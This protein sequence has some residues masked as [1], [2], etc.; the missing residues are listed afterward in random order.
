M[1]RDETRGSIIKQR[2]VAPG[3]TH[4]ILREARAHPSKIDLTTKIFIIYF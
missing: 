1:T 3:E 2:V 4:R